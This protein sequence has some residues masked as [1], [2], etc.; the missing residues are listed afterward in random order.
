M[1]RTTKIHRVAK[2][3][4]MTTRKKEKKVGKPKSSTKAVAT[5]AGANKP[6]GREMKM[7]QQFVFVVTEKSSHYGD[8]NDSILGVYATVEGTSK[9]ILEAFHHST[10]SASQLSRKLS[11][12]RKRP[13]PKD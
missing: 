13:R 8:M 6:S 12:L 5:K 3:Q 4:R 1:G 2:M 10:M 11:R 7:P 9:A